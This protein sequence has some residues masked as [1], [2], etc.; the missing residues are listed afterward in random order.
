[1][2]FEDHDNGTGQTIRSLQR[3]NTLTWF[4]AAGFTA[5]GIYFTPSMSEGEQGIFAAVLFVGAAILQEVRRVR[6]DALRIERSKLHEAFRAM[7][8][9]KERHELGRP[10]P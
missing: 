4:A 2:N 7:A 8:Y 5:G 1:M 10:H 6:I 9:E 3:E